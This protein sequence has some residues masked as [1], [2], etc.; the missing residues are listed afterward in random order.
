M[1]LRCGATV[2]CS[3]SPRLL[4]LAAHLGAAPSA[5]HLLYVIF[6][7]FCGVTLKPCSPVIATVACISPSNS[8]NAMPGLAGI[9]VTSLQPA[10]EG[11]WQQWGG[12][13]EGLSGGQ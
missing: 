6:M 3:R 7:A 4:S 1:T 12:G 2:F 8:T 11:Q 5:S 10:G 13:E 9:T